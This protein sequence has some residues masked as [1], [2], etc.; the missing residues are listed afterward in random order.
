VC[1]EALDG[2]QVPCNAGTE[3]VPNICALPG[4][5]DK[6]LGLLQFFRLIHTAALRYRTRLNNRSQNIRGTRSLRAVRV[7]TGRVGSG[8]GFACLS[9]VGL[10]ELLGTAA[11]NGQRVPLVAGVNAGH[12]NDLANVI[13]RMTQRSGEGQRH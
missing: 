10:I 6:R 4:R 7:N 9:P 13:A 3:Q 2:R 12:L 11:G 1:D 8:V 5:P